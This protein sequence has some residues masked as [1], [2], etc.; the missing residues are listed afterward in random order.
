M[1]IEEKVTNLK[2]RIKMLKDMIQIGEDEIS[3]SKVK[4]RYLSE[5]YK[6]LND[7]YAEIKKHDSNYSISE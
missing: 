5:R 1:S 2:E 6:E 3:N 7:A 4:D